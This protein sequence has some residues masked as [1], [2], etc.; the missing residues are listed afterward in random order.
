MYLFLTHLLIHHYGTIFWTLAGV[1]R[2]ENCQTI[3]PSSYLMVIEC[4][5]L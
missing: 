4:D 3:V 2:L 1:N 5:M